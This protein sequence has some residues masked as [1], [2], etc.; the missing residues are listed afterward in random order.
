MKDAVGAHFAVS[1]CG[2]GFDIE[3]VIYYIV[4]G[5]DDRKDHFTI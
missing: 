5:P 2:L 4:N 1:H 3:Q